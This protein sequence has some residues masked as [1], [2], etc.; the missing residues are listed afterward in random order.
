M[1]EQQQTG[2]SW[3]IV[4][5]LA[6]VA[7]VVAAVGLA[8]IVR[9]SVDDALKMWSGLGVLLGIIA[10]AGATYFPAANATKQA[11]DSAN[12]ARIQAERWHRVSARLALEVPRDRAQRLADI[13]PELAELRRQ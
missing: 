10:G 11:V 13:I 1:N 9:Y 5:F 8:A 12:T 6:I 2:P 4:A 7:F 3:Q